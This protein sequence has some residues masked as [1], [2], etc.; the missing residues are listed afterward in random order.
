MKNNIAR[1]AVGTLLIL[2]IPLLLTLKDGG[3]EGVG[4][5]WSG[6][7]FLVMGALIFGTGVCVDFSWRKVTN[8]IYRTISV[9][10]ILALFLSI[11]GELAVGAVSQLMQWTFGF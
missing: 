3:V 1:I 6:G 9:L 8:P 4:W 2:L 5:N 7:D 10:A 11:W